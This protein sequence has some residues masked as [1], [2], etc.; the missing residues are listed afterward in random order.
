MFKVRCILRFG[1]LPLFEAEK[2]YDAEK[3]K[4]GKVIKVYPHSSHRY[5]YEFKVEDF[6]QYFKKK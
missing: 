5:G 1:M 3:L 6:G 4:G 2:E